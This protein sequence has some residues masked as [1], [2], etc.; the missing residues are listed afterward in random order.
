MKAEG[1]RI[2]K[3]D[4]GANYARTMLMDVSDGTVKIRTVGRPEIIL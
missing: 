3:E 1:I 2:A 4:V